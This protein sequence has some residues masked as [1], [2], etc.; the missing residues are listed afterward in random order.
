MICYTDGNGN[1]FMPGDVNDGN[2]G[3]LVTRSENQGAHTT[4]WMPTASLPLPGWTVAP[5]LTD[6]GGGVWV[7]G[8][9]VDP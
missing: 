8:V 9:L 6:V 3:V 1:Y 2:T 5:N 7:N 4:E